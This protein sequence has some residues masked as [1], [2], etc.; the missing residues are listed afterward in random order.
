MPLQKRASLW[1][2]PVLA[3]VNEKFIG[4]FVIV[5]VSDK[6]NCKTR[7]ELGFTSTLPTQLKRAEN[8]V[9]GI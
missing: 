2:T 7:N 4:S 1:N 3:K 5:S 9:V 6:G 8:Y